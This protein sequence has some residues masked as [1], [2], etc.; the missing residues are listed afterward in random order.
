MHFC[1]G[2]CTHFIVGRSCVLDV[3][4]DVVV[5]RNET[6]VCRL[7]STHY[8]RAG[9]RDERRCEASCELVMHLA[10]P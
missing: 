5:V 9:S 10:Y 7:Y 1:V 6:S 2:V 4:Y 8:L 3:A